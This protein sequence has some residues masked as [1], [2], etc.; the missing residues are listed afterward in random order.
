MKSNVMSVLFRLPE[1]MTA[2]QQLAVFEAQLT[3][4]Y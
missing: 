1:Q 4:I 3:G 2:K